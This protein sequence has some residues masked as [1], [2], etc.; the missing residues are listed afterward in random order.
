MSFYQSSLRKTI[1]WE[2]LGKP[3]VTVD[4][5]GKE[6]WGTLKQQN[7]LGKD[8]R[9]W[10]IHGIQIPENMTDA[11]WK[12]QQSALKSQLAHGRG[13][14]LLQL[15]LTNHLSENTTKS[16]K[17][18]EKKVALHDKRIALRNRLLSTYDLELGLRTHMPDATIVLDLQLST[19]QQK[20]RSTSGRRY[21][22]KWK[23]A[24]LE[25]VQATAKQ[26]EVFRDV[27]YTTWYDKGFSVLPKEK[28]LKLRDYCLSTKQWIL[29]LAL[30]DGKIVSWAVYLYYGKQLIY[31]YG[32]TDRS[33][34]DIWAQYR[35]TDQI[36][37]WWVGEWYTSLDLLG[38]SPVG[39]EGGHARAG[40]TRFKQAFGGETI[41][42]RGSYDIVFNNRVMKAFEWKRKVGGALKWK[43]K[44]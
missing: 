10:M 20:Q 5:F 32:G 41:S 43:K 3:I 29:H 11:Q 35:L 36:I 17:T 27:R 8:L 23:K 1:S 37:E 38:V 9:R 42:Y 39:F 4:W 14:F 25:F 30:Q 19:D 26:R 15:G 21:I 16:V 6:V 44:K 18:A 31:L 22:N 13:D 24:E 2:V 33:Y 34:G 7:H 28:F 12:K 40:V